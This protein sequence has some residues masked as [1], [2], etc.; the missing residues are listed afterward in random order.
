M[1][2]KIKITG[3]GKK[4]KMGIILVTIQLNCKTCSNIL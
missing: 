3:F 1:Y 4:N 2:K